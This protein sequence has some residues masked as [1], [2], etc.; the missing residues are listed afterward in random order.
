MGR[1]AGV[2]VTTVA[3]MLTMMGAN[4]AGSRCRCDDNDDRGQVGREGRE[5]VLLSK[6]LIVANV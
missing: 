3:M 4:G 1:R 6:A 5:L 2:V